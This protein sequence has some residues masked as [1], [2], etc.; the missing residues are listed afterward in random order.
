MWRFSS[1]GALICQSGQKTGRCPR[2]KRIVQGESKSD[3]W[4]GP[5]NIP[6][7]KESFEVNRQRAYDYFNICPRLYVVDVTAGKLQ[8]KKKFRVVTTLAYH[9]LFMQNM[10]EIVH[11]DQ[12]P[13]FT[14]L[15]AG[16]FPANLHTSG[17]TSTT[18]IDISF[19]SAEMVILGTLYAG[20]M[21]KG[22]FS[23]LHY[24]YP[25]RSNILTLHSSANVGPNSD[26]TIFFGLSGTGKTTL[27]MDPKRQ[28]IGDDELAWY[29][30]GVFN[31][32][33]GCYAKVIN[34]NPEHEPYI[35]QAIKFGTVLENVSYSRDT[36]DVDYTDSSLTENTRASYPMSYVPG[37]VLN[38]V[39]PQPT[40]IIFLTCDAFGVLPPV[41]KLNS[42]QALYYFISGYT[43]MIPSTV[44][45]MKEPKVEFS[46][47]F[48]DAFLTLPPQKYSQMLADKLKQTQAAVWLVNTG[49]YGGN[50]TDGKRYPI[51]VSRAI[52]DCIHD[53]T[54][55]QAT[56][57]LF[58]KFGFEVPLQVPGLNSDYFTP[59]KLWSD[60][61]K[62]DQT[63]NHVVTL[64]Q[65]NMKKFD[66]DSH[67]IASGPTL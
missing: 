9:A 47:C 32:E 15:N 67:I 8:F 58:P 5:V 26:V 6:M 59:K 35:A 49:W 65:Q 57:Y 64:F 52:I 44:S 4:W 19:D 1:S 30:D 28:L 60:P 38:G 24:Y 33:S 66:V 46:A 48:G 41:A 61:A 27:S 43:T 63:L 62:Y 3:I 53:G 56:T 25:Q 7:T 21:K 34:L 20:E 50:V 55:T 13:D 12:E 36:F 14:I 39:G 40:N 45:G 2:D 31:I 22:I 16:N 23:V 51:P 29:D 37:A 10:F 18:S 17:M 42:I 54:L 11:D